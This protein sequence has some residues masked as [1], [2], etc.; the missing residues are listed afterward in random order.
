MLII[1]E[2][3]FCIKEFTSKSTKISLAK[4]TSGRDPR[5][6]LSETFA[7]ID[8]NVTDLNRIIRKLQA[9]AFTTTGTLEEAKEM[10]SQ[11]HNSL[12][13]FLKNNIKGE[14]GANI[15]K[16]KTALLFQLVGLIS[17]IANNHPTKLLSSPEFDMQYKEKMS[18]LT[19]GITNFARELKVNDDHWPK[20]DNWKLLQ[21]TLN[22]FAELIYK[23]TLEAKLQIHPTLKSGV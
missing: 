21:S 12:L 17:Y 7:T 13:L 22:S 4:T 20:E 15:P 14:Y 23:G 11:L 18:K 2:I 8:K 5:Q 3:I 9:E 19:S 1:N 6:L 10:F 16:E